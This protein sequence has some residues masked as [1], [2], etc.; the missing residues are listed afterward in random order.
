MPILKGRK[1]YSLENPTNN[2]LD[3]FSQ[4][5][6][7]LPDAK[8]SARRGEDRYTLVLNSTRVTFSS[9]DLNPLS[10]LER[11]EISK[12]WQKEDCVERILIAD[13]YDDSKSWIVEEVLGHL[14]LLGDDAA[15]CVKRLKELTKPR[16][17]QVYR[18]RFA[19]DLEG[20]YYELRESRI[21]YHTSKCSRGLQSLA[22]MR[23]PRNP[24]SLGEQ[25]MKRIF[26]AMLSD[27]R[28]SEEIERVLGP[29]S[30][31]VRNGF[32]RSTKLRADWFFR[33]SEEHSSLSW[34]DMT[35]ELVWLCKYYAGMDV[36]TGCHFPPA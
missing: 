16:G 23:L 29:A 8:V 17:T 9:E 1:R 35:L 21:E 11:L 24:P 27:E 12:K 31:K 15:R 30:Y 25:Q 4:I 34:R 2:L 5:A 36:P 14:A 32:L 6:R 26:D 28:V 19:K 18:D 3:L 22:S 13:V 7:G 20:M 10:K 33:F